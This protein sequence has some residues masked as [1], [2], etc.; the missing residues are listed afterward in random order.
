[1]M[2]TVAGSSMFL[3]TLSGSAFPP[4]STQSQLLHSNIVFLIFPP[5]KFVLVRRLD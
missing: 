1:M 3:T 2:L 4:A 5:S